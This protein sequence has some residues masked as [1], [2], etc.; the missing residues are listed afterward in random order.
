MSDRE[1]KEREIDRALQDHINQSRA[2]V[3]AQKDRRQIVKRDTKQML[4]ILIMGAV[5]WITLIVGLVFISRAVLADQL[6]IHWPPN[7]VADSVTF[8]HVYRI[9]ETDTLLIA[10][11]PGTDTLY[12][13][14]QINQGDLRRYILRAQNRYGYGIPSNEV[15]GLFLTPGLDSLCRITELEVSPDDEAILKWSSA[16][17]SVGGFQY[18]IS[19]AEE[20]ETA[21]DP[22]FR[23]LPPVQDHEHSFPIER[24]YLWAFRPFCYPG[25]EHNLIIGFTETLDVTGT[26]PGE[27]EVEI[28]PF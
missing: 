26:V 2:M 12:E 8:Y 13:T 24:G 5:F 14:E 22:G 7:Q 11:I 28:R 4:T 20:W 18:K 19:G 1:K 15:S 9:I 3:G 10:T 17:P 27:P 21:L 25:A 6:I 16:E 23:L